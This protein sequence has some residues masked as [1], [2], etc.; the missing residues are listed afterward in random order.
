[1]LNKNM[2]EVQLWTIV[3]S[4]LVPNTVSNCKPYKQYIFVSQDFI[5]GKDFLSMTVLYMRMKADRR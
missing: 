2:P 4:N 3:L 1:M 5:H